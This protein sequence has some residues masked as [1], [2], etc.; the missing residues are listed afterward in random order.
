MF[1]WLILLIQIEEIWSIPF[2]DFYKAPQLGA[3]GVKIPIPSPF[4]YFGTAYS[5]I[6]MQENGIITFDEADKGYTLVAFPLKGRPMI[7]PF[8]AQVQARYGI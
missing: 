8:W 6:F 5:S 1:T 2:Q 7:A 4:P 3:Y